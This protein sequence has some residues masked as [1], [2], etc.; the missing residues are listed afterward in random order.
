MIKCTHCGKDISEKDAKYCPHCQKALAQAQLEK[1][2]VVEAVK[3]AVKPM[4]EGIEKSV[5]EIDARLKAIESTP[6]HKMFSVHTGVTAEVYRGYKLADQGEALR[7]KFAANPNRFKSLSK[8][9]KFTEYA[10]FMLDVKAALCGDIQAT[11]KLQA[12]AQAYKSD[13]A[14]GTDNLGGYTV[15][16]EYQM[17]L[18]KLVRENSFALQ[19]CTVINMS[20]NSL[21]MPTE[22]SMV[23]VAWADEA[24]TISASNPTFGQVNLVAKKLTGLTAGISNELL[25]DAG[26]DIV[27]FLTD[28]FMYA[29]GQ[30]LDNQVLNGTGNP[31]SGV[32]SAAAGYSVVMGAGSTNFSSMTADNVRSMIRK[33]SSVDSAVAEF[34]Y[35]KDV[36]YY[37]DVIKD[38]T[39]RYIYREPSGDR[40]AALWNRGVVESAKAPGESDSGTGKGF[41]TLGNW[42]QFYIGQRMGSMAFAADP[43][44]NFAKDQVRFRVISRHALAMARASAFCRLVTA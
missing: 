31:C 10:R 35:G 19:K 23:T 8:G 44:T 40:P 5:S 7:E 6:A 20:S 38:T 26:F 17:D 1:A 32:L 28:Q 30:E 39:G 2:D 3:A 21:K 24:G 43:Y 14:E 18:V 25:M 36:Q 22:A 9:D 41:I 34:I 29:Q 42:K 16:V 4:Q 27:G 37:L 11:M 13:N 33:L 15:P 12:A